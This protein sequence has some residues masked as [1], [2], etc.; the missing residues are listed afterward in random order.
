MSRPYPRSVAFAILL[1]LA[2]SAAAQDEKPAAPPPK[3]EAGKDVN[4]GVNGTPAGGGPG[5]PAAGAQAQAAP[6]PCTPS[7]PADKPTGTSD[8]AGK[9]AV[10]AAIR[11]LM[12]DQS[13]PLVTKWFA[14]AFPTMPVH[15]GPP[16]AFHEGYIALVGEQLR[17]MVEKDMIVVKTLSGRD[18]SADWLSWNN[19]DGYM[20]AGEM[21]I[22]GL[23][24]A[25]QKGASTQRCGD[26]MAQTAVADSV[27]HET[28]HMFHS[29][30][31]C[32]FGGNNVLTPKSVRAKYKWD[33]YW[34]GGASA[35]C[36]GQ[37]CSNC[38]IDADGYYVYK[39]QGGH[40]TRGDGNEY[41]AREIT[42]EMC[43]SKECK[44]HARVLKAAFNA[45]P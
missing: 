32:W 25:V 39:L 19:A 41:L 7:D 11:E 36:S 44:P 21:R 31:S 4:S 20:R 24:N 15:G 23:G 6:G 45:T 9:A 37:Q 18:N 33:H 42:N 27:L 5:Q 14:S 3:F 2:G 40:A 13:R 12:G 34:K 10:L 29:A 38:G 43:A 17:Q 8:P 16:A 26:L 28:A 30:L 35:F 1:A 22:S